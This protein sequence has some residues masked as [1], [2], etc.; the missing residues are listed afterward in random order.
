M[1]YSIRHLEASDH[2][3]VVEVVDAWWGGRSMKH[4][5]PRLFFVHFQP[6]SFILEQDGAMRGFLIGFVSDTN[7]H[8]SYI[9][10][11]GIDP[12]CRG[13]GFGR[14][15]YNHFFEAVKKLGC[16]EVY[17]ITSPVNK[18]SI[19]FHTSMGFEILPGDAEVDG[20]SVTSNY[21]GQGTARVLFRIDL[22]LTK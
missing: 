8:H 7:P 12:A 9:H 2:H 15:L 20:V 10:F 17:C 19:G 18:G 13:Q 5:L 1:N 6:T 22:E 14:I 21:E 3:P 11:V 4:L 16:R